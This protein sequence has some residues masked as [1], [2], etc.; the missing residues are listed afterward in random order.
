VDQ[1]KTAALCE[2][3]EENTQVQRIRLDL[4]NGL[5]VSRPLLNYLQ[6]SP[7]L[8]IVDLVNLNFN[9]AAACTTLLLLLQ[10]IAR[11]QAVHELSV[12]ATLPDTSIFGRVSAILQGT[13][14]DCLLLH[15]G[16]DTSFRQL[17][18]IEYLRLEHIDD[19]LICQILPSLRHLNSL[20]TLSL[21]PSL[22]EQSD[23]T[24]DSIGALL[25]A[26][27][28]LMVLELHD[29]LLTGSRMN[30]V[31][32]GVWNSEC[33]TEL[34]LHSCRLDAVATGRLRA[35]Y[36]RKHKARGATI[37]GLTIGHG[38]KLRAPLV[39]LLQ[40]ILGSGNSTLERLDLKS[41]ESSDEDVLKYLSGRSEEDWFS[42]GWKS[43][44]GHDAK[45]VDVVEEMSQLVELRWGKIKTEE[46]LA[47]MED[48]VSNLTSL[49]RLSVEVDEA[50]NPANILAISKA[51]N[52]EFCTINGKRHDVKS[53]RKK[54]PPKRKKR[55]KVLKRQPTMDSSDDEQKSF[56]GSFDGIGLEA[57]ET[58]EIDEF[59]DQISSSTAGCLDLSQE[60]QDI[61]N[62]TPKVRQQ[63]KSQRII[64]PEKGHASPSSA[65][66]AE[67]TSVATATATV[68]EPHED[69][70]SPR[71]FDS[72]ATSSIIQSVKHYH[73]PLVIARE[74]VEKDHDVCVGNAMG[75]ILLT[76]KS[77][78]PTSPSVDR[79]VDDNNSSSSEL[80]EYTL[81]L[82]KI[83]ST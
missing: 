23:T 32:R 49:Q 20:K 41:R 81:E 67:E 24:F 43:M 31:V 47:L 22:S 53:A 77:F 10:G 79:A 4:A 42:V 15:S 34:G 54:Q 48:L 6:Y 44:T 30:A 5:D 26:S 33:V 13:Q 19:V 3:L 68:L 78:N 72:S 52:I 65:D 1:A 69:G 16:I 39:D 14:K 17:K 64:R 45:Q 40:N 73:G 59:C 70:L 63:G 12:E 35:L 28:S 11:N 57:H 27:E 74:V 8:S 7:K 66:R 60:M 56:E 55:R 18:F 38:V 83:M 37:T 62:D 9:E 2:A 46:G 71:N 61:S 29:C 82:S 58:Q 50:L 36:C 80:L 76:A 25:A 51:S 21:I 75:S